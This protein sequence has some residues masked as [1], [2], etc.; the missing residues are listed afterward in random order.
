MGDFTARCLLCTREAYE[1][2]VAQGW[3]PTTPAEFLACSTVAGVPDPMDL[4]VL[5]RRAVR[6]RPLSRGYAG[7]RMSDSICIPSE[8]VL[9]VV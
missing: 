8:R 4:V 3:G 9:S 1:R 7:G 5:M 2:A 6:A